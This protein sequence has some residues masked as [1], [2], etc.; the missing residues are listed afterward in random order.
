MRRAARICAVLFAT[1]LGSGLAAAPAQAATTGVARMPHAQAVRYTAG[2][3]ATNRVTI[4]YSGR[5]VTIDDRVRIKAG[6]GCKAVKGDATKV[7]CTFPTDYDAYYGTVHVYLGDRGDSLVNR[8]KVQTSVFGGSGNDALQGGSGT[9]TLR[10]ESGKDRLWGNGGDDYLDG[11]SNTDALSGA[12]GNDRLAGGTGHDTLYGGDGEDG[13][14]GGSGDDVLYAGPGYDG[15]NGG[16]G[17]DYL[18]GGSGEDTVGYQDRRDDIVADLDVAKADDGAKGERDTIV[19]DVENL[20]GGSGN[21]VLTGNDGANR[22]YAGSGAD[23]VYAG[24]GND[25]VHGGYGQDMLYGEAG[26]DELNEIGSADD[27]ADRLDG[28][29][30]VTG[31]EC[32]PSTPDVVVNCEITG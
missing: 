17:A 19:S 13:L 18:S 9:D 28:G 10:G 8:S 3:K 2:S 12:A 32:W 16:T 31:D 21:D 15:L 29:D 23:R 4:T 26:D 5:T 25:F 22:F 24:G 6:K 14:H 1:T 20:S 7:R 11:G 27:Y 30:H